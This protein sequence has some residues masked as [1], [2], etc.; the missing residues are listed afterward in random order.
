MGGHF[1]DSIHLALV[2]AQ[3]GADCEEQILLMHV[4]HTAILKPLS[5][6]DTRLH[7]ELT[8]S[9]CADGR[10][11]QQRYCQ[12]YFLSTPVPSFS[13]VAAQ[14]HLA[15]LAELCFSW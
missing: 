12:D 7:S 9:T 6:P 8:L 2:D 11:T 10:F 13:I 5:G 3:R 1:N 4:P 14:V 15:H